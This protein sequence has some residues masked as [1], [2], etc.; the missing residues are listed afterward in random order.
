MLGVS[1]AVSALD[2]AFLHRRNNMPPCELPVVDPLHEE[3]STSASVSLSSRQLLGDHL[4]QSSSLST[5]LL[6][7]TKARPN[8]IVPTQK[9]RFH[10][11]LAIACE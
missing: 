4:G 6:P 11:E 9:T 3:S 10:R 8:R 5:A 7:S 2:D 1:L